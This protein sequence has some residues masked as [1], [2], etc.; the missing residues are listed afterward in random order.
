MGIKAFV[1]ADAKNVYVYNIGK[2]IHT[3]LWTIPMMLLVKEKDGSAK[4][5]LA[6]WVVM[7]LVSPLS[8]MGYIP[9]KQVTILVIKF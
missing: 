3:L 4:K 1:L 6:H 2:S 8:S 7:E 9:L 5:G